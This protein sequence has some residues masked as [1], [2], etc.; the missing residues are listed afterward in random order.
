MITVVFGARGNV[1]RHVLAGLRAAGQDVRATSRNPDGSASVAADLECPETLPAAL[2][3]AR[4]VFLYAHPDHADG[5][6]AAAEAAG[7]RHVVL[8]SSS[9]V[10]GKDADTNP[11]ALRHRAVEAA[12]EASG[13]DWTFIRPGMFATNTLWWWQAPV[14]AGGPIRL[15]YPDA[16]TA[17][18]YEKDLAAIAVTALTGSGHEGRAYTVHGSQALTLREM[19]GHIGDAIGRRIAVEEIPVEQ[20]RGELAATMPSE[21]AEITLRVWA[22]GAERRPP[23]SDAVERIIGRPAQTFAAWARDHAD[24]FRPE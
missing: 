20:A 7:V 18:V 4:K 23:T 17:P 3:G 8:L 19:I 15:P 1:G 21:A 22:A 2:E 6:V 9:S 16:L 24:D 13:L 12:L 5:F 14:R 11:I 10:V